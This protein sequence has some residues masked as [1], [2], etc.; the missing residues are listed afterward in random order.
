[1]K[2]LFN[3][4][5]PV[6]RALSAVADLMLLNLLTLLCCLPVFT[7]GAALTALNAA[8]IKLVRGEEETAVRDFFRGF[9]ANFK[10]G[11]ILG[12]IFLL[13]FGMLAADYLAAG[14]FAPVLRPVIAAIALLVL[15]VGMYA[16]ALPARYE[17]TIAGTLKNAV[18]LAVAYFPRTAGMV[19][20]AMTFWILIVTFL[21]Y[22]APVFILCGLS[23]PC[24]VAVLLLQP[25]FTNLEKS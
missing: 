4:E 15:M 7:M 19:V 9:R 13:I 5:N 3:M 1:M 21:A 16:F 24:Y 20:F 23:L 14:S 8:A 10:K 2:W 6:M 17:N 11:T 12:L 22:G 18:L 25:V